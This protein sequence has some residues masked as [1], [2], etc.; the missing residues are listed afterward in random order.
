MVLRRV[1]FPSASASFSHRVT[2][3]VMHGVEDPRAR[4]PSMTRLLSRP[5]VSALVDHHGRDA[6]AD[7]LRAH[8]ARVRDAVA[9]GGP[10]PADDEVVDA[11]RDDLHRTTRGRTRGV[12][13]ATGVVL[14]TNLGR[15]PLSQAAVAAMVDAAGPSTVEY[16]LDTRS[17][18]RRGAHVAR[19]LAALVGA[20]E[21]LV[22][23][24]GA[25]AL[26]LV[27]A[28][29]AGGRRVA[30]SRG[31]LVEIGGSFRLP[32]I[33]E[34]AGVDLVEVG[35]TN[36][37]RVDDYRW[38]IEEHDDVAAVL[39]VH[40]S[41][42]TIEGFTSRPDAPDLAALARATGVTFV[43]DVGSG[44]LH[45]GMPLPAAHAPEPTM[46]GAV[47]DGADVVVASGDKLLGGPQAGLLVGG[48]RPVDACRR[49]PLARALR[50]DKVRLAALEA[51]LDT[52]RT[53]HL[54][55]LPTWAALTAPV[56]ALRARADAMVTALADARIAVVR[57]DLEAVVG[58]GTLP[59]TTIPS[60]GV[61][62]AGGPDR[63]AAG[64]AEA[65]P[66]V[67]G[68]VD[69]GRLVLDLRTVP[70]ALD[71]QLVAAVRGL[72]P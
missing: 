4:V 21:A 50:V 42:F 61:A 53:G 44:V 67:V 16:D 29:V 48:A 33:I 27:L 59:G 62:L 7:G 54:D 68:R 39:R 19:Q 55:D 30:V 11:V 24:N 25:A 56:E 57:V 47:A 3:M 49:H 31:E 26:V 71:D 51:T 13:N 58:G 52:H 36:R 38:A 20:E 60:A 35:T 37:T 41:N 63:L 9:A 15:A 32:D 18:S 5:D 43:H 14:H 66:P 70:A 46:A 28:A 45:D 1:R 40:P 72:R 2:R 65:D 8:L 23:N 22:V 69:D 34:A 6:V 10:V 12:V 17:R 64:L